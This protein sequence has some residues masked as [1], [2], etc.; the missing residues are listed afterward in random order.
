MHFLEIWPGCIRMLKYIQ[1]TQW[2]EIHLNFNLRFHKKCKVGTLYILKQWDL[3]F[4]WSNQLVSFDDHEVIWKVNRYFSDMF[5][6]ANR[7]F[8]IVYTVT[9]TKTIFS[10]DKKPH[11]LIIHATFHLWAKMRLQNKFDSHGDL[12]DSCKVCTMLS[13]KW[14]NLAESCVYDQ[15]V[16]L[17]YPKRRFFLFEWM[18]T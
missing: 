13:R 17:F 5:R 18:R 8:E 1:N 11:T 4:D 14:Q 9:Q 16:R 10:L 7:W 6:S 15:C 12:H 3:I 2:G